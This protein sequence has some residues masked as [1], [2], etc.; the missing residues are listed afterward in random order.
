M[1]T[2]VI[3]AHIV[4]LYYVYLV[5]VVLTVKCCEDSFSSPSSVP[6]QIACYRKQNEF[7]LLQLLPALDCV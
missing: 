2:F 1:K 7:P 6:T 4:V 3:D 5:V